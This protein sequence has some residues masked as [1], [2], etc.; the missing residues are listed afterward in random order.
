[1]YPGTGRNWMKY[2]SGQTKLGQLAIPGAHDSGAFRV[3]F[4]AGECHDWSPEEQ[5]NKGKFETLL[6]LCLSSC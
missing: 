2:V 3:P 5:M 6:S 4:N 1:M